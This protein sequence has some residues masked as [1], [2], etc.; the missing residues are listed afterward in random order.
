MK[1]IYS[2]L[3]KFG[4]TIPEDKK[5]EFDKLVLE[6]YK[7][8]AE[9]QSIQDKLEKAESERD[10]YHT[11]Y[12]TDIAQRD[13][14]LAELQK[15]LKDAGDNSEELETVRGELESLKTKYGDDKKDWTAQL[16]KQQYEFAVKQKVGGI[17]FTSNAAK[18]K[19]ITDV[20]AQELKMDGDTLLGFDDYVNTYK[21]KDAGAFIVKD[22]KGDPKPKPSFSGPSNKEDQDQKKGGETEKPKE[23]P[24]IW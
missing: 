5:E 19:F 23:R 2:I 7:T 20:L 11:K 8:I 21:E 1:N 16:K 4:I 14:D 22:D 18:E 3:E 12:D 17:Q 15:K 24:L 6:N 10:N 13:K 9:V